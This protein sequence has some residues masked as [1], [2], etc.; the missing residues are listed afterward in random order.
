MIQGQAK[1]AQRRAEY[2]KLA[3]QVQFQVQEAHAQVER[4]RKTVKLYEDSILKA[5]QANIKARKRPT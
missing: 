2:T 3:D 4:G 5:A 1:I